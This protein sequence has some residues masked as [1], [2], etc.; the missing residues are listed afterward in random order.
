MDF[1]YVDYFGKDPSTG[2]ETLLYDAMIGD[3][4]LFQRADMV[5]A[6]WS[7]GAAG[8][9]RLEG[10]AGPE[11]PELPGGELGPARG[12]RAAPP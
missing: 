1:D 6:G 5:E 3:A 8:P 11:L 10:A 9:R 7:D 12:R 2:Y 4:T